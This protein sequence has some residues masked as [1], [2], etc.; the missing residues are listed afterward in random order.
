MLTPGIH[1]AYEQGAGQLAEVEGV[2]RIGLAAPPR[3]RT[4]AR[5]ALFETTAARFLADHRTQAEVFGPSSLLV[6]CRDADEMLAVARHLEGQLTAT[7]QADAADHA[8]AGNLLTVL[9]RKA[10]RVLFNGYPTGVE[11]SFA[12]VHG[13]PFPATSDTRAR[14]RSA[15]APSN[16]SCARCATRTC[17]PNCCRRPL[18]DA[19]PL[20]LWRLRDGE[21]VKG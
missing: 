11:V 1:R 7:V 16:A 8:Q 13:G 2:Q 5:P 15:P 12:M 17:R 19:N 20:N 4:G 18:Q 9:E 10:G 14:P 21:P 3:A 6:V